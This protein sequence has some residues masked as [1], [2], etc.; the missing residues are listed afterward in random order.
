MRSAESIAHMVVFPTETCLNLG[1]D[2]RVH[3]DP[4][5]LAGVIPSR[6]YR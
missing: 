5:G 4:V 1:A 3:L 2:I 6:R